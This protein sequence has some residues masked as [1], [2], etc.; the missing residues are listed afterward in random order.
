MRQQKKNGNTV[1][2][3]MLNLYMAYLKQKQYKM[4]DGKL[5]C[6]ICNYD[7]NF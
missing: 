7:W 5:Q 2:S 4:L 6:L 3:E 1:Q